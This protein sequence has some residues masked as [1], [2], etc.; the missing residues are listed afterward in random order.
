VDIQQTKAALDDTLENIAQ[1]LR[2]AFETG[3]RYGLV[4]Q[5]EGLDKCTNELVTDQASSA[6]P[7]P[8][9]NAEYTRDFLEKRFDNWFDKKSHP[10]RVQKLGYAVRGVLP[11]RFDVWL[12]AVS[13]KRAVELLL[14]GKSDLMVGWS[15]TDGIME[16]PI[17]EVVSK[18]NRPPKEIWS[19][20]ESWQNIA[21]LQRMLSQP[22]G[23]KH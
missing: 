15:E 16:I 8:F 12:G 1:G 4:I 23:S 21:E 11:S 20:R 18:S 17:S 5:A 9:M 7:M 2:K 14:E 10:V 6:S 3:K 19:E 22:I 13:G